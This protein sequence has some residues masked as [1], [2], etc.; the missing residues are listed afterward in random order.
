[1]RCSCEM[2]AEE[3]HHAL[4]R[5]IV[6]EPSQVLCSFTGKLLTSG[7]ELVF[8]GGKRGFAVPRMSQ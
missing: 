3:V 2:L 5:G 1:M 8:I 4:G 7:E 6:E